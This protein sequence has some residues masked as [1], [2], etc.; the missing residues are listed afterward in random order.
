MFWPERVFGLW[1]NLMGCRVIFLE[2][3][4]IPE[5][6][7]NCIKG[8]DGLIDGDLEIIVLRGEGRIQYEYCIRSYLTN[9]DFWAMHMDTVILFESYVLFANLADIV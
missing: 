9:G 4:G 6:Q 7:K 2:L 8:I 1:V 3:L 5:V